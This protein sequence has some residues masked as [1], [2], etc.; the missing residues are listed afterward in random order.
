VQGAS[1]GPARSVEIGQHVG[2]PGACLRA[3]G[4]GSRAGVLGRSC[5][6]PRVAQHGAARLGGGECRPGTLADQPR[7]QLGDGGHLRQQELAH[8]PRRHAGQ[9]AEHDAGLA[10]ALDDVQQEARVAGQPVELGDHQR[11]TAG[12]A[13]GEGCC[14]LRSVGALAALHLLELGHHYA[15]GAGHVLGHRRALR[16]Q[17]QP[18]LS[19]PIGADPVVG[20]EAQR[21]RHRG[22]EA[23]HGRAHGHPGQGR[24]GK[25]ADEREGGHDLAAVSFRR[26][27]HWRMLEINAL[28][29]SSEHRPDQETPAAR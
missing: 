2:R 26:P 23:R 27:L 6:Q 10:G 11:R 3:F 8:R 1:A 15:A 24:G 25:R 20:H 22:S 28:L 14:E 19:L 12:A 4:H 7:L 16:L 21:R 5:P 18:T 13:G 29:R 17:A 9:V